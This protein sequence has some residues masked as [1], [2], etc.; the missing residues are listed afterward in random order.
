M[1]LFFATSVPFFPLPPF[2]PPPSLSLC[3]STQERE[4]ERSGG[5]RGALYTPLLGGAY[6]RFDKNKRA[7]VCTSVCVCVLFAL[8]CG[9][10]TEWGRGPGSA[11]SEYHGPPAAVCA[12]SLRT[13]DLWLPS[14]HCSSFLLVV[15]TLGK[16][17]RVAQCPTPNPPPHPRRYSERLE[18]RVGGPPH[19]AAAGPHHMMSL[20]YASL[21]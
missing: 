10:R 2:L 13:N 6:S 17:G 8:P 4:R 11:R 18:W 21:P 12:P 14:R 20:R 19:C 3:R 15:C 7:N 1:C 5:G 16:A 9:L